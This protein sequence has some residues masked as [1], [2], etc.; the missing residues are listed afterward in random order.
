MTPV[1]FTDR[2][3][4]NLFPELLREAGV[5]V[6]KHSD[7]FPDDTKDEEW[8]KQ[9]GQKGWFC[10]TRDQRIR[11]K[12]NEKDAVMRAG[13]GLFI[14]VSRRATHQELAINLI[15]TLH[16]VERF[17][18][19]QERPFIAKIFCPPKEFRSFSSK[20]SGRVELWLSYEEWMKS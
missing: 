6:K 1:F 2:D 15:K 13:V 16:K 19:K 7:H 18:E 10:L 17:V 4:G 9:A 20:R 8:L 14:L 3:L 5:N 12:P 11:Y